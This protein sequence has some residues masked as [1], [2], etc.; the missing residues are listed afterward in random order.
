MNGKFY[1]A[2][3][4]LPDSTKPHCTHK[5]LGEQ[6]LI[7]FTTIVRFINSYQVETL[8][9]PRPHFKTV[10]YFGK[11][12]SPVRVLTT[13]DL[14]CFAP[15]YHLRKILDN[16]NL[17]DFPFRPHLTMEAFTSVSAPFTHYALCSGREVIFAWP[18]KKTNL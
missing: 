16:F 11:P 8:S 9:V 6:S 7:S 15:F 13:T 12:E 5:Y 1:T 14:E 4:Y 17:N 3:L 18:L 2:F 10:E